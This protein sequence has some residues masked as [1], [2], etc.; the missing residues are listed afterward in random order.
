MP[1]I[2]ATAGIARQH[3][4]ASFL[5]PLAA[6]FPAFSAYSVG[7]G[8][9]YDVDVFGRTR[10]SIE[11]AAADKDVQQ[12]ALLA[13]QLSIAGDTVLEALQVASTRAQIDVVNSVIASDQRTQRGRE[14]TGGLTCRPR[15]APQWSE[16]F[17]QKFCPAV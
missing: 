3:Y 1:Q 11:L 8:V 12:E 15:N 6:T 16:A 13:A 2:D 7:V 10:R 17:T 4:G 9:T 5:G 14:W